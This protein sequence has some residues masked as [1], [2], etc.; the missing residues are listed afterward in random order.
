[1]KTDKINSFK[2][3]FKASQAAR[4]TNEIDL[5]GK[6][7]SMRPSIPHKS[8]KAYSRK[9]VKANILKNW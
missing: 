3:N 6:L 8:K 9:M 4:R 7:V 1:M 2:I 5:Y